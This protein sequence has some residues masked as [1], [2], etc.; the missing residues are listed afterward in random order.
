MCDDADDLCAI[1]WH[2]QSNTF[3]QCR[4]GMC[5]E[6][7]DRLF[8]LDHRCPICRQ[9]ILFYTPPLLHGFSDKD[10]T[11]IIRRAGTKRTFGLT[12]VTK[13]GNV[14][15]SQSARRYKNNGLCKEAVVLGIDNLPVKNLNILMKILETRDEATLR[16][17][18]QTHGKRS[19]LAFIK[20]FMSTV[21]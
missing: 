4:H 14:I 11:H 12:F 9:P 2:K 16:T 7:A 1:C 10:D 8:T 5:A 17:H 3:T 6:C 19:V 20:S 13:E 18:R 15:I 21:F